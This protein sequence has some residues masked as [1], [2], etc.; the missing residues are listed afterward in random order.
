[1]FALYTNGGEAT[2]VHFTPVLVS[3]TWI[4]KVGIGYAYF[5]GCAF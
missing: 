3:Q 5:F 1:M 2:P 4:L